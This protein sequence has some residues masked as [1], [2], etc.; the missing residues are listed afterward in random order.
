MGLFDDAAR[1]EL[2]AGWIDGNLAG[3]KQKVTGPNGLAV[4]P[5][6]AWRAGSSDDVQPVVTRRHLSLPV[7]TCRHL[8]GNLGDFVRAN[9]P[10]A[11]ADATVGAVHV[12]AHALEVRLETP[13][14][15]VVGVAVRST[16]NRGLSADFANLGHGGLWSF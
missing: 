4:R 2:A 14:P 7:V 11:R 6:G 16:H 10:R 13:R 1:N 9:A 5:D 15:H 3:G 8:S 12:G